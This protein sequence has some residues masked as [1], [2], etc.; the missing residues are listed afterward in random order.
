M[1]FGNERRL[2]FIVS[3]D[4]I[5]EL[6]IYKG[7]PK[8]VIELIEVNQNYVGLKRWLIEE[9]LFRLGLLVKSLLKKGN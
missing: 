7:F 8:T 6:T 3:E 9:N 4:L 5:E 1:R 2:D